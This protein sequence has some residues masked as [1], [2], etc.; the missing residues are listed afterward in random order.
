MALE[1]CNSCDNADIRNLQVQLGWFITGLFI[2]PSPMNYLQFSE[3]NRFCVFGAGSFPCTCAEGSSG[4][5]GGS[6][7]AWRSSRGCMGHGDMGTVWSH[8]S[9]GHISRDGFTPSPET[10]GTL[11]QKCCLNIA[12][13]LTRSLWELPLQLSLF[14]HPCLLFVSLLDLTVPAVT[15]ILGDAT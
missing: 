15:Q 9:L 12:V 3:K 8:G 14:Q 1:R 11:R 7:P 13:C 4:S 2:E 6:S 5:G 10:P